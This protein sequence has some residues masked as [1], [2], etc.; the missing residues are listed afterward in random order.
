MDINF[1]VLVND[2]AIPERQGESCKYIV[3]QKG[4]EYKLRVSNYKSRRVLAVI[5][6]DG[7]SVM[8]GQP[9][10][11][12]SSGGYILKSNE[13]IEIPGWRLNNYE[14][15]KFYFSSIDESYSHLMGKSTNIGVIACAFFVDKEEISHSN[16][17]SGE[18][19]FGWR[20]GVEK[21][22]IGTGFG[23][24]Q[25]HHVTEIEFKR[26]SKPYYVHIVYY[27][28]NFHSASHPTN[29]NLFSGC[30]PPPG[31]QR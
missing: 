14:V 2:Q 5:T 29:K 21:Q 3:V 25:S 18:C 10:D 1:E 9:G 19:K 4:H 6:V 30:K 26:E 7:L 8:D 12:L 23:Q 13:S 16:I 27:L 20:G 28:E 11:I 31:W 17:I 24:V 22:T 15:A